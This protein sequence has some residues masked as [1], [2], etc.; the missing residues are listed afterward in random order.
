MFSIFIILGTIIAISLLVYEVKTYEMQ[1]NNK[2]IATLILF[3]NAMMMFY[4]MARQNKIIFRDTIIHE[5]ERVVENEWEDNYGLLPKVKEDYDKCDNF[6][7]KLEN[8]EK[9]FSQFGQDNVFWD[10]FKN[11]K[12][13]T[14]VDLAACWPKRLSNTYFFETCMGWDG[15]CI[16]ADPR[17]IIDLV[18]NRTCRVVPECV[19]QTR[20]EVRFGSAEII[21]TNSINNKGTMSLTCETFD[22]LLKK[23]GSPK[24]IDLLSLDIEGSEAGALLSLNGDYTFDFIDIELYNIRDNK[25]KSDVI[26]DFLISNDYIPIVGFPVKKRN[27]CNSI[28]PGNK[29]W[30]RTVEDIFSNEFIKDSKKRYQTHDVLFVRKDSKHLHRVKKLFNNC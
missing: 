20:Q 10:I 28:E 29:I 13:G 22:Y 30:G 26:R 18:K 17:K 4:D 16:E 23:Y 7:K 14:F 9:L 21:G 12:K 2:K 27:Y 3:I 24:Q 8:N 6:I 11:F 5:T 1:K 15:L 25:E 19:T